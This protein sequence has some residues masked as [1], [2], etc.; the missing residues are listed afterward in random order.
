MIS[1]MTYTVSCLASLWEPA[2]RPFLAE[3]AIEP[4][5]HRFEHGY[6]YAKISV[7][8]ATAEAIGERFYIEENQ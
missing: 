4:I 1:R 6:A 2:L 3:L 7:D 8:A 5:S